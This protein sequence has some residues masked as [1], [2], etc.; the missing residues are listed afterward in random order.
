MLSRAL[1][2]G[3]GALLYL[4]YRGSTDASGGTY[5]APSYVVG[6]FDTG[7]P[8]YTWLNTV[9]AIGEGR[10]DVPE[11]VSYHFYELR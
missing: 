11:I 8:R 1:I 4:N 5:T 3:D 9:L 10:H 6:L 2:T 7:D